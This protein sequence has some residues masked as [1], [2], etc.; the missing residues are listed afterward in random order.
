MVYE[1]YQDDT[2]G[3]MV[4]DTWQDWDAYNGGAAEWW[5]NT[6]VPGC[7]QATPCSWN[8]IVGL[9]A[10][11]TIEEGINCGPGGVVAPCPGSLGLNQ[12]SGNENTH[13]NADALYVS[14][15]GDETTYD[16]ELTLPPPTSAEQCKN[17]GWQHYGTTFKHQGDCVSFVKTNGKN[18]SGKN[19]KG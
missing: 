10:N 19:T 7:G 15:N 14:V 11:A 2:A 17:G 9:F 18:E 6:G 1:P 5:V 8:T 12:G 4:D 3:P 13:S 16:F